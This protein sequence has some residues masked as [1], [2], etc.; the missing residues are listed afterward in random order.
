MGCNRQNCTRSQKEKTTYGSVKFLKQYVLKLHTIRSRVTCNPLDQS[1][2]LEN[3][4]D[5]LNCL[6]HLICNALWKI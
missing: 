6:H 3:G 1:L 4:E 5:L 2:L